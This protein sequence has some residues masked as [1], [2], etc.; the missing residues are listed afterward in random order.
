MC[1]QYA[2]Y[3]SSFRASFSALRR[4]CIV[5]RYHTETAQRK[6]T[7]VKPSNWVYLLLKKGFTKTQAA[8]LT[9]CFSVIW[10]TVSEGSMNRKHI[11]SYPLLLDYYFIYIL[12]ASL[13]VLLYF[14]LNGKKRY[15][16]IRV[17]ECFELLTNNTY[18]GCYTQSW[19]KS[20]NVKRSRIAFSPIQPFCWIQGQIE[21]IQ[22][23]SWADV[24]RVSSSRWTVGCMEDDYS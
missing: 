1:I 3:I 10:T 2:L 18:L 13:P 17:Q 8:V 5:R 6:M 23:Q 9:V 19:T 12:I 7:E 16:P 15:K 22:N 14:N 20:L 24:D 21:M 4:V 11:A